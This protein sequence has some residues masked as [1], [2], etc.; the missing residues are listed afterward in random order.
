MFP[1]SIVNIKENLQRVQD[2]IAQAALKVG[3]SPEEVTLVAVSKKQ[4]PEKIRMAV[5]AGA[6]VFGENYVQEAQE[7]ISFLGRTEQSDHDM[8]FFPCLWHFIGHLQSNKAKFVVPLFTMIHTVDSLD[9]AR[10]ISQRAGMEGKTQQMLIQVN[11]A[12]EESKSGTST[13]EALEL[14]EKVSE[15]PHISLEG[16]MTVPP[17]LDDP[18]QVRPYFIRLRDLRDH[19]NQYLPRPLRHL[20]MGMSNDFEVAIEEG[21]TLVRV[22]SAIFGPRA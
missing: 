4:S 12:E 3:R 22:G 20:S 13:E 14:A 10:I 8:V 11:V 2:R 5:D 17:F 16:L 19:L 15:L 6:S 9:L 1:N 21:A 7:K 18:D